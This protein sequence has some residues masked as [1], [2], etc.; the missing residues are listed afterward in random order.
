MK[1]TRNHILPVFDN[2][3]FIGIIHIDDL[4]T[5]IYQTIEDQKNNL[6]GVTHD[7]KNP[8]YNI[9]SLASLLKS[10]LEPEEVEELA[11]KTEEACNYAIEI[12]SDILQSRKQDEK[13]EEIINLER[14]GINT[15][16]LECIR[17]VK[18]LADSKSIT[19]VSKF[20]EEEFYLPVQKIKFKRAIN[21]LLSNAIKF[22][23]AGGEI[24]ITSYNEGDAILLKI[25]D[26]GIGI[27]QAMQPF[28]FT[29][30]TKAK[31]AG[32]KGEPS[33]GLGL[34]ITQQ[35]IEEHNG[36]LWFESND[37]TGTS[38]FIKLGNQASQQKNKN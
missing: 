30:F 8:I 26:N 13:E 14:A 19:I 5:H 24:I 23:A 35:I 37:E 1:Q 17:V 29:R 20:S 10:G 12:I 21:N 36:H 11:L 27:P 32:T 22:T 18:P 3:Q 7:L 31:R 15:L 9:M 4:L 6:W 2:N 16:V 28:I 33:T 34:Y 25:K 38:F